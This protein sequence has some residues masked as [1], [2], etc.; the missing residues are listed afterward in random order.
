[1]L[2][3][4]S[5]ALPEHTQHASPTAP[6]HNRR[7]SDSSP[8]PSL[9]VIA[10]AVL[11]VA[12]PLGAVE[13]LADGVGRAEAAA[14]PSATAS[15]P[16]SGGQKAAAAVVRPKVFASARKRVADSRCSHSRTLPRCRHLSDTAAVR[17]T[18]RRRYPAT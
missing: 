1:M 17:S 9:K 16:K 3:L 13:P 11:A 8:L 15:V 7:K 12:L 2:L 14:R 6:L 5:T 18:D 4:C 10:L